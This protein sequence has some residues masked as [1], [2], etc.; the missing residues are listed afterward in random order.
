MPKSWIPPI[1]GCL[2]YNSVL[3]NNVAFVRRYIAGLEKKP[4]YGSVCHPFVLCIAAILGNVAMLTELTRLDRMRIRLAIVY[5][6]HCGNVSAVDYLYDRYLA[7]APTD[8]DTVNTQITK[9]AKQSKNTL[10]IEYAALLVANDIDKRFKVRQYDILRRT[11]VREAQSVR[12]VEGNDMHN[13]ICLGDV[14]RVRSLANDIDATSS[15]FT[16]ILASVLGNT[17]IVNILIQA[18]AHMSLDMYTTAAAT[19]NVPVLILLMEALVRRGHMPFVPVA[20]LLQAA[21]FSTNADAV[22]VILNILPTPVSFKAASFAY[23]QPV[24]IPSRIVDA[25]IQPVIDAYSSALFLSPT[26]QSVPEVYSKIDIHA[27]ALYNNMLVLQR[28]DLQLKLRRLYEKYMAITPLCSACSIP[29]LHHNPFHAWI[30]G[31]DA[32]SITAYY[33]AYY[34]RIGIWQD[35][36]DGLNNDMATTSMYPNL[37]RYGSVN[38]WLSFEPAG[39]EYACVTAALIGSSNIMDLL[40]HHDCPVTM[41]AMQMATMVGNVHVLHQMLEWYEGDIKLH[42]VQSPHEGSDTDTRETPYQRR[43][44]HETTIKALMK[45]AQDEDQLVIVQYLNRVYPTQLGLDMNPDD[46]ELMPHARSLAENERM[47]IEDFKHMQ[48]TPTIRHNIIRP[49]RRSALCVCAAAGNL[50]G[51]KTLLQTSYAPTTQKHG[52]PPIT[53][54]PHTITIHTIVGGAEYVD[55]LLTAG[56]VPDQAAFM[57]AA[58]F[59]KVDVMMNLLRWYSVQ[60]EYGLDKDAILKAAIYSNSTV[61]LELVHTRLPGLVYDERKHNPFSKKVFVST[62]VFVGMYDATVAFAK[63]LFV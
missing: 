31:S 39:N 21:M 55:A 4:G 28:N 50:S 9:T 37:S 2:F 56:C 41:F 15:T 18:G 7:D 62:T 17:E 35:P 33:Q 59:G 49:S 46:L 32:N 22:N 1:D 58:M 54:T 43:T 25:N 11:E 30:L 53:F 42:M 63:S 45:V 24:Y 13:A 12:L 27:Q 47:S 10:M 29:E 14:D 51:F 5:A 20:A 52:I 6:V 8:R 60:V 3:V 23:Q 16:L 44:K 26:E 19:G 48:R 38:D 34:S 57:L 40:L 61:M 36:L